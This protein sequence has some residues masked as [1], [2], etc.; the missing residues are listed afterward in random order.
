MPHFNLMLRRKAVSII[1][2][3]GVKEIDEK[4]S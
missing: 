1:Q 3:K 4:L 2:Q